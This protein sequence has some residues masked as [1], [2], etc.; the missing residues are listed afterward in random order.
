[1]WDI[2]PQYFSLFSVGPF[3]SR[4]PFNSLVMARTTGDLWKQ[5]PS[6]NMTK[7]QLLELANAKDTRVLHLYRKNSEHRVSIT[8]PSIDWSLI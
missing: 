2:N 4:I 5:T 1:V 8:D 7:A 3:P 6:T